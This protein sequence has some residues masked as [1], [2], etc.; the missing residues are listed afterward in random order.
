MKLFN[1][2]NFNILHEEEFKSSN[3]KVKINVSQYE[4]DASSKN[5]FGKIA[6][7]V[8]SVLAAAKKNNGE[9]SKN[10]KDGIDKILYGKS[11]DYSS[12]N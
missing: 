4:K 7:F 9:I 6:D 12:K 10:Q 3:Q 11:T 5:L 1:Y 2:K 8:K